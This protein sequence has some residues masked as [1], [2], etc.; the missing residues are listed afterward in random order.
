MK[1]TNKDLIINVPLEGAPKSKKDLFELIANKLI[2]KKFIKDKNEL[3]NGFLK[4]E[5][6][7]STG[8]VEGFAIPHTINKEIVEPKVVILR[9][10]KPLSNEKYSSLD[11]KE[12]T[13]IISIIV[14]Q[15]GRNDHLSILSSLSGKLANKEFAAQFIKGSIPKLVDLVNNIEQDKK[16][17]TNQH[18]HNSK[19]FN[20][21]AVTSCPT[22]IAHTYMAA[23]SL[24]EAA[25]KLGISIKVE[26]QGQTVQNIL[27]Q[28]EINDAEFI[29]LGI[30]REIEMNRFSGKSVFKTGTKPIIKDATKIINQMINK[31]VEIT[32]IA[33]QVAG[34]SSVDLAKGAGEL[35]F[36][37]F[38]KRSWKAVMNG[39]SYMLPFVIFGGI[40]LA[41]SFL[42]DI[43]NAGAD[44]FGSGSA[45]ASWFNGIGGLSMGLMVPVLTA[46]TMYALIGRQGLLPG[47]IIGFIAAGS[48]P[49]FTDIF[50]LYGENAIP[51]WLYDIQ[52]GYAGTVPSS[53][54]IGGIAG[55]FLAVSIIIPISWG[56]DKLPK[57]LRGV[58]QILLLPLLGTGA[59][60]VVFWFIN[61]P[62][63]Y[64]TWGLL[65]GLSLMSNT[66]SLIW[67]LCLMLAMMM[68]IDMGGPIN[69]TAYVFGITSL[70]WAGGSL[71]TGV[72]G[73]N[74]GYSIYMAAVM[75]GGMVPPLS[76]AIA[77]MFGRNKL[78]DQ[79][80]VEAGY[81]NW[82]MGASFITEG[83]I[84]FASK[85]P[86]QVMPSVITGSAIAGLI[87][88]IFSVSIAA[89]HGGIFVF[90]LLNTS[91]GSI[92]AGTGVS[93]GTGIVFYLIAISA[94]SLT[95]AGMIYWLR[96]KEVTKRPIANPAKT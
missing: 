58:K 26:T 44:N 74:E 34:G 54:F 57:S 61:I 56:L 68:A 11:G 90:P 12:I 92:N 76:L 51:N 80:D 14:P 60:V 47:F 89:P 5:E 7:G 41:L 37:N 46:Y 63:I 91:I 28:Q 83:A 24:E 43:N 95:A 72:G 96:L 35:S 2:D 42:I 75:A 70:S 30:D 65:G 81:S 4:R 9:L 33:T 36:E 86:K 62:L 23:E 82:I 1:L 79:Q 55:A 45:V 13:T 32:Q 10:K 22:G 77:T 17:E 73:A 88:G 59:V 21:V 67:L 15:N 29:I 53:G 94:G 39:V 6:Q 8:M 93:I 27:T 40:F 78:W 31:E 19:T 48:G 69:K 20:I 16:Q 25:K 50:N 38:G 71:G 66:P 3:I 85:Y 64:L 18:E 87:V 49:A 52:P 84:P